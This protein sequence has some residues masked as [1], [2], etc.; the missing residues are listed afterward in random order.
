MPSKQA[1]VE[2][3]REFYGERAA[4]ISDDSLYGSFMEHTGLTGT[5]AEMYPQPSGM[6]IFSAGLRQT[7]IKHYN[8][9]WDRGLYTEADALPPVAGGMAATAVTGNLAAAPYG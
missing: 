8:S 9:F 2:T 1:I 3:L 5:K 7:P 6:E 4:T